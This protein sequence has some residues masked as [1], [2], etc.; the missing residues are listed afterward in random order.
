[1]RLL[2][3]TAS[4]STNKEDVTKMIATYDL[5]GA[6]AF[7]STWSIEDAGYQAMGIKFK[8]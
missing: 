8:F 5:G 3:L 7:F 6:T 4:L 2:T 1:M